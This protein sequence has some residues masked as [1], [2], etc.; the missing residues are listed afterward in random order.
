M[1]TLC[2]QKLNV[3]IPLVLIF[4]HKT[5]AKISGLVKEKQEIIIPHI[6][7]KQ[8]YPL[9]FE[10][11]Q[12]LFIEEMGKGGSAYHI[13]YFSVLERDADLSLL[14]NA[15]NQLANR[16]S[17]LKS[18]YRFEDEDKYE[19]EQVILNGDIPVKHEQAESEEALLAAVETCIATPFNLSQ[20]AGMRIHTWSVGDD[21]YLLILFHHIA[22]DGWS[23]RIFMFELAQVYQDLIKGKASTLTETTINYGDYA[24]W[25]RNLFSE[26]KLGNFYDFW[27]T[28]L[29]GISPLTLPLDFPRPPFSD[30]AG[31]NYRIDFASEFFHELKKVTKE[32]GTTLHTIFLSAFF[33]TLSSVC[34][35]ND[36]V[37]GMPSDNRDSSQVQEIVGLFTNTLALRS[38]IRPDVTL[39]DY[40]AEVHQHV[41]QAKSHQQLPFSKVVEMLG[42]KPDLSINPIYQVL[43]SLVDSRVPEQ[44][45]QRLPIDFNTFH[46]ENKR[47]KIT[48]YSPAKVDLSLELIIQGEH[49]YGGFIYATSLMKESTVAVIAERFKEIMTALTHERENDLQT[50]LAQVICQNLKSESV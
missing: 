44:Y 10:Q 33:L 15:I 21:T 6:E 26:D 32:E 30:H 8:R 28:Q 45:K 24:Y 1:G 4:K 35:Q 27:H 16:H 22:F 37:I 17:I 31:K 38:K 19:Y 39:S 5:I 48:Q 23:E 46:I 41:A 3:D 2:R 42:I 47:Q 20:E 13:P 14:L 9:S 18:V 50:V 36:I 40:I 25:Q 49:I 11:E 34:E 7:N 12:L 29:T 43:F